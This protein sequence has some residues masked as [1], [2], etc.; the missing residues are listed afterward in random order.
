MRI[1]IHFFLLLSTLIPAACAKRITDTG[2]QTSNTITQI[3][4]VDISATL[5]AL[6]LGSNVETSRIVLQAFFD[7]YN[8]HDIEGVLMTL[9]KTFAYSDCDV[10]ARH[11]FVFETKED[12]AMWLEMKFSEGDHIIV[13]K[14]IIAPA[15]GS[16][17]NEPRSTAVEVFRT[18]TILKEK[19]GLFKI[20][21]NEEGNRIQYLNAYGNV[22][23]E[24]G[25]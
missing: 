1:I 21:L 16:P 4:I 7:A 6:P 8:R 2:E 18:S 23:C 9:A 20:I 17:P 13:G 11:M 3:P 19:E 15:E 12:L 24:A 10:V 22:D 5:I 25:R 14:M